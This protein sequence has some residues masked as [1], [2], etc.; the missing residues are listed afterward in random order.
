MGYLTK[1]IAKEAGLPFEE[2]PV[3][4]KYLAEKLLH[5][6]ACFGTEE[7]GGYAWK[8][9][10]PERDGT[11][12]FLL[13]AEMVMNTGKTISALWA[14]MEKKY[15]KSC[16]IRRDFGLV[17]PIPNKHS[18]AVKI[19]K[20]L[21]KTLVGHKITETNTIDGLKIIL[22]NDWWVLMRPSGT[23]PLLRTYAETESKETASKLLDLAYKLAAGK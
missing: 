5:E 11:L 21:P 9:N 7:S 13:T 18:F 10:Q 20:K 16:F 1:R 6:G 3:G 23:E 4:F 19:K 17:K 15:G 14:E 2:T 12:S 22:E 8:G